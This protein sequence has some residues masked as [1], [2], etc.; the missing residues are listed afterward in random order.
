MSTNG[1][2]SAT[3]CDRAA[4]E[5]WKQYA[6]K[7]AG[8][9]GSLILG[10]SWPTSV[11]LPDS[12]AAAEIDWLIRVVVAIRSAR[13][14]LNVPAGGKFEVLVQG[15][16][17]ATLD[18]V[19]R[20]NSQLVRQANLASIEPLSGSDLP[21]GAAQIVV[22]EVTYVLP[23]AG[24]IDI[25]AEVARLEKAIE[26]ADQAII[27]VDKQLSNENFVAKAPPAA[28]EKAKAGRVEAESNKAGLTQAL[29]RL[30]AL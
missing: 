14:D 18:K 25:A 19:A 29:E 27:K 17:A 2:S 4:F 6:A 5:L 12:P 11:A 3:A 24:L 1:S 16:D 13:S 15:A 9:E 7:A 8:R 28:I 22:D 26:K 21:K 10:N 23:L 20:H 30:K